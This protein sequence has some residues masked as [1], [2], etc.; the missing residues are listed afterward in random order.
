[1]DYHHLTRK[2]H[3]LIAQLWNNGISIRQIAY[4]L[5]R[6]PCTISREIKRNRE[7][8]KYLS[9]PAQAAYLERRMK[10][11]KRRLYKEEALAQYITEK[12]WLAWSPEQI[13]GRIQLDYP[14]DTGMRISH[15]SIYRW[16][17][18]G[19][20]P[21]AAQLKMKLRHYGHRHAEKRGT[22][23][24]ARELRERS[25]AVLQRKRLGDWEADTIVSSRSEVVRLVNITDRT[26]RYCCLAILRDTRKKDM[27]RA[28]TFFFGSGTLPLQTMTS[29]RGSEFNCH[30]EFEEQYKALYYYTRP[31]SP[32]QKP[33]VENTNG[34]IRQFF[35]R[36][37]NFTELSQEAVTFVMDLL[38][39]RPRKC[40]AWKTPAEV[41]FP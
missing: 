9:A 33:T 14:T 7:T 13:A 35:P 27:L 3:G 18:L 19:L 37:T 32:W 38:N 23:I 34:L 31:S 24:G 10:C 5:K 16:L 2:E 39:N 6:P 41:L 8:S 11:H 30:R 22:K 40:L 4:R 15:S 28:F 26:S 12:L 20:L 21:C 1:M 17:R 29:D 25:K 36:G